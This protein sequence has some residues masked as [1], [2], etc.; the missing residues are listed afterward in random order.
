LITNN[1]QTLINAVVEC[2]NLDELTSLTDELEKLLRNP[3]ELLVQFHLL[4]LKPSSFARLNSSGLSTMIVTNDVT[5][6]LS[7]AAAAAEDDDSLYEFMNLYYSDEVVDCRNMKDAAD[8]ILDD[9]V[10]ANAS[11]YKEENSPVE[12][13]PEQ[14]HRPHLPTLETDIELNTEPDEPQSQ[15][16]NTDLLMN[17][18]VVSGTNVTPRKNKS[19]RSENKPRTISGK[20]DNEKKRGRP[21][22]SPCDKKPKVK[23]FKAAKKVVNEL[24]DCDDEEL[25]R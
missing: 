23:N 6:L 20:C 17:S 14:S 25:D 10:A 4:S 24:S 13:E 22:V 15:Y 9:L 18:F 12:D 21:L 16:A 2:E 7:A 3:T 19:P 8:I 11:F 5:N 1:E